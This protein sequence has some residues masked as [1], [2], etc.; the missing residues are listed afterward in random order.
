MHVSGGRWSGQLTY[1]T[2]RTQAATLEAVETSA[3]DGALI[4]IVQ[5]RVTLPASPAVAVKLLSQ[6]PQGC[7]RA[8]RRPSGAG[9]VAMLNTGTLTIASPAGGTPIVSPVQAD[10]DG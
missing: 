3:K 5:I 9:R 2:T 4:C 8:V 1:H 10:G 7:L 6:Y